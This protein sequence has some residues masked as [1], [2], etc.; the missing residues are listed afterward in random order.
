M[1]YCSDNSQKAGRRKLN[2]ELLHKKAAAAFKEYIFS[3]FVLIDFSKNSSCQ[4]KP[5][6]F[7]SGLCVC[8]S[9][10]LLILKDFFVTDIIRLV[11]IAHTW[12]RNFG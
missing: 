1:N 2:I 9:V 12:Q 5:K 10:T 11:Q 3:W 4:T 8:L 6:A 7:F